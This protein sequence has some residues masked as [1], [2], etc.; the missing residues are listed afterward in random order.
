M[1]QNG[2]QGLLTAENLEKYMAWRDKP[3]EVDDL[4]YERLPMMAVRNYLN[5]DEDEQWPLCW[6]QGRSTRI[7]LA[8]C[9][10]ALKGWNAFRGPS[11]VAE[12]TRVALR[13]CVPGVVQGFQGWLKDRKIYSVWDAVRNQEQSEELIEKMSDAVVKVSACKR[14]KAPN[15][16]LGS[17]VLHFFFPEFF[18]VW[19]TAWI[20]KTILHLE[21]ESV[22]SNGDDA[23]D[24]GHEY[25][26]YLHLMF[27]NIRQTTQGKV[28]TLGSVV[29]GYSAKQNKHDALKAIVEQNL[30]DL[31]PILF[32]LCLMGRGRVL[33]IL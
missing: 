24:P 19:D 26:Q 27:Q 31:S 10:E 9:I 6:N 29:V 2:E 25:A 4:I 13:A 23:D 7:G 30:W 21:G 3:W 16:M 28:K 18:P 32:E 11:G 5:D 17:K 12:P 33:G 1:A 15:P 8:L 20:K 14:L 22:E